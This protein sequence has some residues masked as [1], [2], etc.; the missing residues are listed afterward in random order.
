[1]YVIPFSMGPLD[2]PLSKLGVQI[3]DSSFVVANM[4]IM[5]RTGDPVVAKMG[6][7]K[8]KGANKGEEAMRDEGIVRCLHSVGV[9]LQPGQKVFF[10]PLECNLF[11]YFWH[12]VQISNRLRFILFLKNFKRV[13]RG[14][15][16]SPTALSFTSLNPS[17]SNRLEAGTAGTRC[18]ARNAWRCAS[19]RGWA[20]RR[21]G[22]PNTCS[23]VFCDYFSLTI[24]W[25]FFFLTGY[26]FFL[27][28]VQILGLT[29]PQGKKHYIAAAFPSACG[30]TNLA[31][32]KPT[33]PGW[34]VEVV[35][36]DIACTSSPFLTFFFFL[37]FAARPVLTSF[38]NFF[39]CCSIPTGMKFDK[40]GTLRA[41]NPEYGFFGVAPG[42][43][44]ATNP[45]AMDSI[46]NNTIFTNVA[47]TSDGDV[48]WEGMPAPA[49]G[50]KVVD[51]H[52]QPWDAV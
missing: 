37:F 41:I 20:R 27:S 25:I 26:F 12:F 40:E 15:A 32:M 51:W 7:K 9:P 46:K 4:N 45:N 2:S 50:T 42:T 36:D 17:R 1:M 44:Y 35:G 21:D 14:L 49:A 33:L 39:F 19:P 43:S 48:W 34:K 11:I 5:A 47:T 13:R 24:F 18:S 22:L 38:L 3:T 6:E 28:G 16:T 52:G 23:C 31:M 10:F 30:K 8:S 29:S